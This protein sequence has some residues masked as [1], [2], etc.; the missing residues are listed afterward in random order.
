MR[1]VRRDVIAAAK[2]K[3][4]VWLG[5]TLYDV[6]AGW[7]SFPLDGSQGSSRF[8]GYGDQFD[9]ATTSPGWDTVALIASTGT[10]ALL[11]AADGRPI[12]EVNRSYYHAEAYRY[13]LVLCT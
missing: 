7:R 13:P 2:A 3:A 9:A 12:R 11:L 10:K 1:E 8:G 5:D 6:A 4:L